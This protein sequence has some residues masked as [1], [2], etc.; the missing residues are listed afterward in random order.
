MFRKIFSL[1]FVLYFLLGGISECYAAKIGICMPNTVVPRWPTDGATLKEELEATDNEVVLVF[2]DNKKETQIAQIEEMI[3]QKCDALLVVP[4]DGRSLTEVLDKAK[5]AGIK[6]ISYDRLI[7][8]SDAVSYY[9]S[10]DNFKVGLLQGEYIE[11]KLNLKNDTTPKN[12]EF[13][14]GS[15]DDNNVNFLW[16]G[17]MEILKPYLVSGRLVCKSNQTSKEDAAVHRWL[18]ENAKERMTKLI[19]A[20][21]YG[22]KPDQTRLDAILCPNDTVANAI[23]EVLTKLCGYDASNMPVIT[24]QDC[25]KPGAKNIR[26]GLQSMC[27]FKDSRILAIHVVDMVNQMLSGE[28]VDVNDTT[29]YD[30]GTGVIPAYLC[31]PKVVNKENIKEILIDTGYYSL[32]DLK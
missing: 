5:K 29:S 12:I 25:S 11:D 27:V 13:F 4:V 1:S 10:F 16:A 9:A 22:P 15:I 17:D 28:E 32:K 6:I 24:G 19:Q 20:H 7:M 3:A 30:N 23:I 14:T 8:N 2:A 26:N 31:D 18:A 21:N